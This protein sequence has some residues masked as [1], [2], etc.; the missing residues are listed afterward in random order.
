MASIV[1]SAACGE[2]VVRFRDASVALSPS[3]W[4]R[5]VVGTKVIL[6]SWLTA[7]PEG[8]E[9]KVARTEMR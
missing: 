7:R 8:T 5:C 1:K 6:V 2:S 9:R 4:L 3:D